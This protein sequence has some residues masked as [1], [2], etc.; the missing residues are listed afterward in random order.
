MWERTCRCVDGTTET[1]YSQKSRRLS[2]QLHSWTAQQN[3]FWRCSVVSEFLESHP[4]CKQAA[5]VCDTQSFCVIAQP[6][7]TNTVHSRGTR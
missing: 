6:F 1:T 3:M 4:K 2:V 7:C 5:D